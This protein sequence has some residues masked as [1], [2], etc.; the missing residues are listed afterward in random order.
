MDKNEI[1]IK[2]DGF[3]FSQPIVN[4]QALWVGGEKSI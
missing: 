3:I 1:S 2:G 4:N